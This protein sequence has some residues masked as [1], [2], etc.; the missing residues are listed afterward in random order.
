[1]VD[2][3]RVHYAESTDAEIFCSSNHVRHG[4]HDLDLH[5]TGTTLHDE[6]TQVQCR[7][8]PEKTYSR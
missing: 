8:I 7:V 3:G 2:M 6:Q 4:E 1:M 5:R